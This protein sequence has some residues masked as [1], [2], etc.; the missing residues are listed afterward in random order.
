MVQNIQP[1][2]FN[3]QPV[4]NPIHGHVFNANFNP[5]E[6]EEYLEQ[7]KINRTE[8]QFEEF[9]FSERVQLFGIWK[10]N[11]YNIVF[12]EIHIS[13]DDLPDYPYRISFDEGFIPGQ[14]ARHI[15][16]NVP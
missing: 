6:Y 10:R 1:Q 16:D 5:L 14:M 15:I 9:C 12:G 13:L 7:Q 4:Q 11:I 3:I 2:V 8:E